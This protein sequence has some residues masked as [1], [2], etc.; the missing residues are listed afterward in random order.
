MNRIRWTPEAA[1]D[2]EAIRDFIGRDSPHYA[3]AVVAQILGAI[4]QLELFLRSGRVVPEL[5]RDDVRELIQGPYRIVYRV[6]PDDIAHILVVFRASRP[7]PQ[8]PDA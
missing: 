7:L 8:L 2:L 1:A 4:D 3:A 6:L 5:Q